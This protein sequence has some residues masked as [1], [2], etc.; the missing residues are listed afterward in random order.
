MVEIKVALSYE[1]VIFLD[2]T[3]LDRNMVDLPCQKIEV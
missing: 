1:K 2:N 3:L